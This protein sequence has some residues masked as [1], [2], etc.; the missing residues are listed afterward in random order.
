MYKLLF[1]S[2]ILGTTTSVAIAA[3]LS[4]MLF[5]RE[6]ARGICESGELVCG[7]GCIATTDTCCPDGSG[8]CPA[9]KYCELG[10]NNQYGCCPIGKVCYG[11]GGVNSC[12][13]QGQKDCGSDCIDLSWTCCPDG[14]G[15][16]AS[17][18][19][20]AIGS[21]NQYSCCPN[22][23]VCTGGG[24][25]TGTCASQ[26]QKDCGSGCIDLSWTCCPDGSGGCASTEYCVLGLNN[27]YGCCAIGEVCTGDGSASTTGGGV[28]GGGGETVTDIA[29]S[30]PPPT[31]AP[32]QINNFVSTT[33]TPIATTAAISP[34][35]SKSATTT[36]TA[37]P[38]SGAAKGGYGVTS[39]V[40][41]LGAVLA[42]LFLFQSMATL[43]G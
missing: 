6:M 7:T 28:G 35:S 13:S 29:S 42:A 11:N 38:L 2:L 20:C 26:N 4:L 34:T 27:Q 37:V 21:N 25:G 41:T 36:T 1:L 30:A 24:G 19:Y 10:A 31:Q 15:G 43:M 8:S 14:S 40:H 33:E 9:S 17:T 22:G 23:Q 12:A 32:T 39:A 18:E 16:C 5:G 3:N